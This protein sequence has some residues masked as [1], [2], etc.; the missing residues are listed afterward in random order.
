MRIFAKCE[1]ID[2]DYSSTFVYK[3][4]DGELSHILSQ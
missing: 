1:N 2:D 3:S 4:K